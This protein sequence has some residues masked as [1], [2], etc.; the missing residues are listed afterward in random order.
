[1]TVVIYDTSAIIRG[2]LNFK[3][4]GCAYTT[5]SVLRELKKR[6]ANYTK[7]VA[8]IEANIL[9]V[10]SPS[11]KVIEIVKEKAAQL[12]ELGKISSTDLE[13]I[14][15]AMSFRNKEEDILV[16]TND[17]AIQNILSH[18][19]IK[20]KSIGQRE[21]REPRE[22][23]Y[24]CKNCHSRYETKYSF[25]PKCGGRI[26]TKIIRKDLGFNKTP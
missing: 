1:M 19:N 12:G 21:I 13:I 5:Y 22:Y 20:Y 14:A 25:C 3:N 8:L 10:L 26:I 23:V 2:I 16:V 4:I 15:L 7:V 18:L 6:N 11:K 9:E 17:F 24:E